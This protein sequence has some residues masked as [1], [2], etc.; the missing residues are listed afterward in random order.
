[1]VRDPALEGAHGV[2]VLEL[3]FIS[4][5][6]NLPLGIFSAS[7]LLLPAPTPPAPQTYQVQTLEGE[8]S[9]STPT[10][11]TAIQFWHLTTQSQH[12]THKLKLSVPN[13]TAVTADVRTPTLWG[14]PGHPQ[15]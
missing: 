4:F 5:T 14:S 1:M 13:K 12:R 10:G 6:V 11:C 8:Y 7:F 9:I 3:C 15:S 2:T